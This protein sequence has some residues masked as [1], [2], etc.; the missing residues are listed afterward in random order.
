[1]SNYKNRLK[2]A[3]QEEFD[4]VF[5][6]ENSK[7]KQ[8]FS[9]KINCPVCNSSNK[10]L[11]YEKDLFTFSECSECSMIY[12]NPRLNDKAT[13]D[14]YNGE[15]TKIY[16]EQKF[17]VDNEDLN[18][19]D[20]T[21]DLENLSLIKKYKPKGGK[22]LEIGIG[23]GHFLRNALESKFDVFGVELNKENCEKA[24]NQL[25]GHGTIINNDLFEASFKNDFFDVVYM[26]DVFEHVPN[27]TEMLEEINRISS[28]GAVLF[29]EVPN[30][31]GAIFKLV[32][33]KH[34]TIFGFEHLNYWSPKTL[35]LAFEKNNFSLAEEIHQSDD[36]T[37]PYILNYLYFDSHTSLN[38][39][40]RN[41]LILFLLKVVKYLFRI[42][43]IS[44]FNL[45][46]NQVVDKLNM[47]SQIKVIGIKNK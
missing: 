46:T 12:L 30:I 26:K 37:I 2:Q 44:Y 29:I 38:V 47:G 28:K 7:M 11:K 41:K 15:W 3:L 9:L 5:D 19:F 43:G 36:F 20:D 23:K 8:E 31:D 21:R 27:P 1:M 33:E 14:F 42:K 16:N 6:R 25:S 32:K 4:K 18:N 13:Y 40:K 35:S 45:L 34:V 24:N 22:L 39:L 10:H 17:K